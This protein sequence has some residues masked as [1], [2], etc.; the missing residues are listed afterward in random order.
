L[1]LLLLLLWCFLLL[2]AKFWQALGCSGATW[3]DAVEASVLRLLFTGR[4][5]SMM[6]MIKIIL[7]Y[8]VIF[9]TTTADTILLL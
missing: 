2:V 7:N 4:S 5:S 1:L 9:I 6:I 3:W 8:I